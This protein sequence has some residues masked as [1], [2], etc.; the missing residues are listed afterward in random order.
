MPSDFRWHSF[1]VSAGYLPDTYNL[2]MMICNPIFFYCKRQI[3]KY[4][5]KLILSKFIKP[6]SNQHLL[7]CQSLFKELT[8]LLVSDIN[9][10]QRK[11]LIVSCRFRIVRD[12]P[13]FA[14]R[15]GYSKLDL[16]PECHQPSFVRFLTIHNMLHLK[17]LPTNWIFHHLSEVE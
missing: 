10:L 3:F 6:F 1:L 15:T 14:V 9:Y 8:V 7:S 2:W 16:I 13:C 17:G 4:L 5:H 12:K 11:R